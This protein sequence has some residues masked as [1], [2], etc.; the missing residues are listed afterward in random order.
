MGLFLKFHLLSSHFTF[1]KWS[2]RP[3]EGGNRVWHFLFALLT[4]VSARG[5]EKQDVESGL[6]FVS[7]DSTRLYSAT[8]SVQSCVHKSAREKMFWIANDTK[9]ANGGEVV[10]GNWAFVTKLLCQM[11]VIRRGESCLHT[12][13]SANGASVTRLSGR[14]RVR[15]GA[16]P[17]TGYD[18]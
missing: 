10:G 3:S 13:Q 2:D 5:A 1:I 8:V 16:F 12:V 17:L 18:E 14:E 7:P 15:E 6:V 9:G 4:A 11:G